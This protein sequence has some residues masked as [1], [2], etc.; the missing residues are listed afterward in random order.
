MIEKKMPV[1]G[2]SGPHEDH[3][4]GVVICWPSGVLYETQAG[5]IA[6]HHPSAEGV[7]VPLDGALGLEGED[8]AVDHVGC[9]GDVSD[10][11]C[12]VMEQ[13][14]RGSKLS[15]RM[16]ETRREQAMEAWWPVVVLPAPGEYDP[17]EG[18]PGRAGWLVTGNCD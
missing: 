12:G 17:L 5:G 10:S 15:L 7:L 16:D 11:D 2:V 1:I 3:V 13:Y 6:C 18:F 14:L 4:I 8:L 9:F